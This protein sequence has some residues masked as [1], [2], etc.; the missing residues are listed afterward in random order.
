MSLDDVLAR[1][2]G[3]AGTIVDVDEPHLKLVVFSLDGDWYAF[4]GERIREVLA[5]CPVFFL[6]GCPP[7][8]EGV[9]NVRGEIESVLLLRSILGYPET[10]DTANSRILIGQGKAMRSGIR[11]DRVEDVVDLPASRLEAPPHTIPDHLAALVL[12]L[13]SFG[14]RY[15]SVL[16]LERL[17]DDYRAGLR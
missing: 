12:G 3:E 11:V 10:A 7:S 2:R 16:D 17:F 4:H 1:R 13:V 5:D 8:L 9:I 6:P 15:V 14:G